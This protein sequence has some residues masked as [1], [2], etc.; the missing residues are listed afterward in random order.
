MEKEL[1]DSVKSN[2]I[3]VSNLGLN[4]ED[5]LVGTQ[6][7]IERYAAI[8][9]LTD[10]NHKY[11]IVVINKTRNGYTVVDCVGNKI[12]LSECDLIHYAKCHGA[13]IGRAHV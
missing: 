10:L 9:T 4:E 12:V 8:G 1:I 2:K 7:T 3:R 5:R 13:E 11:P 6:G